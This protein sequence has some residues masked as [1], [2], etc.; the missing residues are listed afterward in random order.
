MGYYT[1]HTLSVIEGNPDLIRQ[2]RDECEEAQYCLDENGNCNEEGKWYE[3]DKDMKAFSLKHPEALFEMNG[4]GENSD[5][6]WRQYWKNGKVQN[7][8]TERTYEPF[9]NEKLEDI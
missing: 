8:E 5:D 6:I 7:V 4:S 1:Q 9:D 3:S 2:F